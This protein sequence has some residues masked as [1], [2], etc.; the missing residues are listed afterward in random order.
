M[1]LYKF[2]FNIVICFHF[3]P[4]TWGHNRQFRLDLSEN[5]INLV[6]LGANGLADTFAHDIRVS[7]QPF[8][9]ISSSWYYAVLLIK[10]GLNM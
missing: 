9:C 1:L 6:I 3:R 4:E 7:V 8:M 2:F 10:S 5:V